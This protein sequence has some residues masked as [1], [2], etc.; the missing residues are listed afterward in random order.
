MHGGKLIR[1]PDRDYHK[2]DE[3]G[4]IDGAAASETRVAADEDHQDVRDPHGDGEENFGVGEERRTDGLQSEHGAYEEASGHAGEAEAEGVEGDLV[5]G[6]ERRQPGARGLRAL[7]FEAAFLDEIEQA[8]DK[9]EEE[10]GVGGEEKSDME[11]EPSGVGW[12][13]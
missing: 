2:K 4:E 11:E 6:F 1:R 12:T 10:R 3:A 7:L 8:G 9:R 13:S 5:E